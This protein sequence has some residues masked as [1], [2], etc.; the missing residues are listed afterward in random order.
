[1]SKS[2]KLSGVMMYNETAKIG[3]MTTPMREELNTCTPVDHVP[4]VG[5]Q[6]TRIDR[7][8]ACMERELKN[9]EERLLPVLKEDNTKGKGIDEPTPILCPV[10]S[11]LRGVAEHI[12][13]FTE[14]LESIIA[15]IEV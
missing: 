4:Q 9:L 3:T 11:H 14:R 1:M 10:A 8:L 7:E 2:S 5:V 13:H 15:R 12:Q 6:C